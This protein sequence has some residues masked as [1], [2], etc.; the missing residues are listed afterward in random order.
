MI[1]FLADGD[2]PQL[3][4]GDLTSSHSVMFSK[5]KMLTLNDILCDP[6]KALPL[7]RGDTQRQQTVI[8]CH[9]T[10]DGKVIGYR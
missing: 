7:P 8:V 5:I 3:K 9:V 2:C 1:H 6:S 10:T 4:I